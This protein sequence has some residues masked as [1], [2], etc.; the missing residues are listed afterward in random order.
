MTLYTKKLVESKTRTY[1]GRVGQDCIPT[2]MFAQETRV[3]RT[4]QRIEDGTGILDARS[5]SKAYFGVQNHTFY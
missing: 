5:G 1:Y 3:P 4:L 2:D